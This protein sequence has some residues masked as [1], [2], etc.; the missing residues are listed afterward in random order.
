M[1]KKHTRKG[2]TRHRIQPLFFSII[3]LLVSRFHQY[4]TIQ[5]GL[6]ELVNTTV[7]RNLQAVGRDSVVL[8]QNIH[9]CLCT[10]QAQL[11]VELRSTCGRVGIT[12]YGVSRV[13]KGRGVLIS[14]IDGY[15]IKVRAFPSP[16]FLLFRRYASL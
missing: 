5:D 16:D 9:Y 10:F 4:H 7:G 1:V 13:R 6:S 8:H 3:Y 15:K 14:C 11:L 12:I 2:C